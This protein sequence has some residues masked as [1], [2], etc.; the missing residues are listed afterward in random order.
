MT[1]KPPAFVIRKKNL[2]RQF[3][4]FITIPENN[5][6]VQLMDRVRL[7]ELYKVVATISPVRT[8]RLHR[9]QN[10]RRPAR[11]KSVFSGQP[12]KM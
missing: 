5:V 2:D 10:Q 12:G 7:Q 8:P 4:R 3:I 6:T 9:N 1:G 11:L